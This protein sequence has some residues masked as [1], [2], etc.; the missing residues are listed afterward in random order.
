MQKVDLKKAGLKSTLPRQRVLAKLEQH[1]DRHWSAEDVFRSMLKDD[2]DVSL[3]TVYR[4]LAQFET[5]GIV[6]RQNF[7]D[8]HAMF[9]LDSGVHHDHLV[10][11][12]CGIIVEFVD[13]VIEARQLEVAKTHGFNLADHS[14]VI[15]GRCRKCRD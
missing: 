9:E 10:C 13:D 8:G 5:A 1:P 14:L 11:V 6:S 7:E 15:Y 3:A 2:E 4:V 12:S